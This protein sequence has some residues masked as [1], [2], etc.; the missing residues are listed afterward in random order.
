MP[1]NQDG[2]AA[3]RSRKTLRI[4]YAML[5]SGRLYLP[6]EGGYS[7]PGIGANG[8]FIA[9]NAVNG[10]LVNTIDNEPVFLK[11]NTQLDANAVAVS[12]NTIYCLCG[13]AAGN[14][15]V[16]LNTETDSLNWN[17]A[18][19]SGDAGSVQ[20]LALFG[21]RIYLNGH[22]EVAITG[23][24]GEPDEESRSWFGSYDAVTGYLVWEKTYNESL[25][26]G[27]LVIEGNFLYSIVEGSQLAKIDAATGSLNLINYGALVY[28]EPR[29]FNSYLIYSAPD[30]AGAKLYRYHL[31]DVQPF[32]FVDKISGQIR[33][34]INR[35]ADEDEFAIASRDAFYDSRD[36]SSATVE[37]AEIFA[38]N[39][40]TG[41]KK[42]TLTV[43]GTDHLTAEA[44][45]GNTLFVATGEEGVSSA[46]IA[47][48]Q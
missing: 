37:Q 45:A 36:L 42:W 39:P 14:Y 5:E 48:G 40:A 41:A 18:V 20:H 6:A 33:L 28:R 2:F 35:N 11:Y 13:N 46:I 12:N 8:G 22:K 1:V 23:S 31:G 29:D 16:S 30:T 47:I 9:L 44:L 4:R 25:G 17:V 43:G 27:P 15:L 38:V 26:A 3:V 19:P 34:V 21:N 7:A 24:G 10:Q 32:I